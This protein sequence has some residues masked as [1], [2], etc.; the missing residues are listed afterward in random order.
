MTKS[1]DFNT[2]QPK[3]VTLRDTTAVEC[4]E[5]KN[6]TFTEA[7]VMRRVSRLLTGAPK[8]SYV[9]I[10]V[11]LCSACGHVNEEFIPAELKAENATPSVL[12]KA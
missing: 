7:V 10:P 12:V 6:T 5:C 2:P 8:D 9:P 11:F 3:S 1:L 4:D